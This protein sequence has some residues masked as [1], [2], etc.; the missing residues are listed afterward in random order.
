MSYLEDT[1]LGKETLIFQPHPLYRHVLVNENGEIRY[2][3][4]WYNTNMSVNSHTVL[5]HDAPSIEL[6][7]EGY[8]YV[9]ITVMP[10]IQKKFLVHRLIADTFCGKPDTSEPLYVNHK[11]GNKHNN[12]A[13]NLE[14]VTMEENNRHFVEQLRTEA[15]RGCIYDI[16]PVYQYAID[17]TLV[18]VHAA[19][20]ELQTGYSIG[21]ISQVCN[22]EHVQKLYKGYYWSYIPVNNVPEM[23]R[24]NLADILR[25][26]YVIMKSGLV[27]AILHKK[28]V[29]M[30][31]GPY[32]SVE[33]AQEALINEWLELYIQDNHV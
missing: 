9:N 30:R 20:S 16:K 1:I 22:K 19:L 26:H 6:H 27:Y 3:I 24:R 31:F 29:R 15:Q 23:I 12:K 10:R 14:W 18:C 2:D 5:R 21:R 13:S 7:K 11:D 28:G 4:A 33:T 25:K 32:S 8:L 17:G